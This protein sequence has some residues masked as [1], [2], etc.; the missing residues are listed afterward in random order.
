MKQ[1]L[2]MDMDGVLA[3]V[4]AQFI[5][6]EYEISGTFF[7][8]ED[9]YGILEGN[10]FP[11]ASEIVNSKGFFRTAPCI[12]GSVEGLKYLNDKYNVL[13]VSSATEFPNSL[14]EKLEWLNEFYPFIT[15]LQMIFCGKKDSIMGD[16]MVDDHPKNLDNF[17]GKTYLFTQPHNYYVQD[18]RHTRVGSWQ[19]LVKIL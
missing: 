18:S 3:D 11:H 2:L 15:W 12:E 5:K 9:L 19:E 10:A 14:K 1:Q 6:K 17:S 7:R 4:Y 8:T 16:I 13:I